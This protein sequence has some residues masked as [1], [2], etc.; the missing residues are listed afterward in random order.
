MMEMG[1]PPIVLEFHDEALDQAAIL[2]QT[3]AN[4]RIVQTRKAWPP[5][6]SIDVAADLEVSRPAH[7][8]ARLAF[9]AT[10]RTYTLPPPYVLN[11]E[12]WERS[13]AAWAEAE[14]LIRSGWRPGMEP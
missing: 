3:M 14:S 1:R 4:L 9:F 7:E 6:T 5:P 8:L 13:C 10:N 2:C 12:W 11:D